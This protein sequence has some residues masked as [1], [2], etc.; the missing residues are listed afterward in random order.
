MRNIVCYWFILL[1]LLGSGDVVS[2]RIEKIK[3]IVDYVNPYIDSHKSRFFY[4]SSA[5]RP[6][7]MVNLSPDNYVNGSWKSG[8]LYDSTY[9]R[10]IS[11]VHAWQLSG[12][13]VM[14]TVG[15]MKGHMGMEAYK[16]VFSHDGEIVEPGYHK[17]LLKDYNIGV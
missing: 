1:L 15:E 14:P 5:S 7:G 2:Q 4:F 11:H 12:I 16:S 9:V 3:K 6:F 17:L 10:C 8:Y 13:P